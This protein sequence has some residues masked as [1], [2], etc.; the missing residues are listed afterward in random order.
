MEGQEKCVNDHRCSNEVETWR[1]ELMEVELGR[2]EK[3]N[4]WRDSNTQN[5]GLYAVENGKHC[6]VELWWYLEGGEPP[7]MVFYKVSA[8]PASEWIK[9]VKSSR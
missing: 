3:I 2:Q 9:K 4:M 1:Q 7:G 6:R 8:V 5:C